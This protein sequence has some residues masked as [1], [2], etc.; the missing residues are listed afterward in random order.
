MNSN[1][2]AVSD[3]LLIQ[4]GKIDIKRPISDTKKGPVQGVKSA[5]DINDLL[6]NHIKQ[7]HHR[8]VGCEHYKHKGCGG[9][10]QEGESGLRKDL[11][12]EERDTGEQ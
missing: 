2:L 5:E 7:K 11:N 4:D 8:E 3:Q 6:F 9:D 10:H 1:C 12:K